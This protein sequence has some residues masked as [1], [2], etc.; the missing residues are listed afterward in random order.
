MREVTIS[1]EPIELYKLL[2]F[3]SMVASGGEAKHVI[4][5]G[6]VRLNGQVETQKRKKI[7]AGDIVE[8]G[9]EKIRIQKL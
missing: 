7:I 2:K 4:T 6:L 3:E 9:N 8:F 1:S 5:A